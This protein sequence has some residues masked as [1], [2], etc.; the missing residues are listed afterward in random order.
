[1]K[2]ENHWDYDRR[3]RSKRGSLEHFFP[4]ATMGLLERKGTKHPI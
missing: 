1:M 3:E 2:P 4:V